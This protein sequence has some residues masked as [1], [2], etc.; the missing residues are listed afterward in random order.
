[1]QQ[2]NYEFVSKRHK[3]LLAQTESYSYEQ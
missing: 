3:N 2:L 1:M